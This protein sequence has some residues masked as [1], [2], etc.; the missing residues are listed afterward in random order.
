MKR[1]MV[2]TFG[3]LGWA[4][5]S[6][7]GG[8][9]FSAGT[10][11]VDLPAMVR[12]AEAETLPAASVDTAVEPEVTRASTA[13][14]TDVGPAESRATV[15]KAAATAKSMDLALA[16]VPD[17]PIAASFEPESAEPETPADLRKVTGSRVNL[18]YGPGTSYSVV[19]QLAEGDRVEVLSDPGDGWVKLQAQDGGTAGWMYDAYLAAA[20][21]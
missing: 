19:G 16:A 21:N 11:G 10:N 12:A 14:L 15:T 8:A 5:Y 4:W 9:E 17:K 7:S 6:M 20:V 3:L 13:S 1:L 2:L 18:R